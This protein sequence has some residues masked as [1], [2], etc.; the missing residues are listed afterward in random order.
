MRRP[1]T[2]MNRDTKH[3]TARSRVSSCLWVWSAACAALVVTGC[4]KPA[5]FSLNLVHLHSQDA[6]DE[7]GQVTLSPAA[8]QNIA[9]VLAALYGTPAAPRLPPARAAR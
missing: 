7:E 5:Q 4:A 8:R 1:V 2:E 3:R 6:P 9:T